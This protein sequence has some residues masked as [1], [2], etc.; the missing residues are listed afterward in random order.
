VI[1]VLIVDDHPAIRAGLVSLL[2]AEPDFEVVGEAPDGWVAV[3]QVRALE[4][5]LVLMDLSMP[6]FDGV[7]ATRAIMATGIDTKVVVLTT[8]SSSENLNAALD[9]GAH[10]YLTKDVEPSVLVA[11]L[12]SAVSGG[13]PLSPSVAIH[14]LARRTTDSAAAATALSPRE[15]E[16]LRLLLDGRSNKQI[17]RELGISEQ[18][19]K[20]HFGRIFQR[21]DV[22][23][24][25]QAALWAAAHLPPAPDAG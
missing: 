11:G 19:V 2:G 4:P 10:G 14:L 5:D 17:A 7:D 15:Q 3:E 22:R 6:G 8:Y 23:D 9:A 16:I 1:R 12:R 24:R 13:A 18:T 21:I 25:T 20:T